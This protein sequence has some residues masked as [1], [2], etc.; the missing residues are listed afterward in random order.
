MEKVTQKQFL[1]ARRK[2]VFEWITF[3]IG[4]GLIGMF[5]FWFLLSIVAWTCVVSDWPSWERLVFSILSLIWLA[6]I[7]PNITSN[8]AEEFRQL[9]K[10]SNQWELEAWCRRYGFKYI[11]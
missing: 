8:C 1:K 7:V 10:V 4:G 11:R 5:S 9:K 2:I 6:L 3:S